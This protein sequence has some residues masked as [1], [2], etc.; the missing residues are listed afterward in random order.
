MKK[1]VLLVLTM[2][3]ILGCTAQ[4]FAATLT[5]YEEQVSTD[6]YL[7]GA[8][9]MLEKTSDDAAWL[10][11][12]LTRAKNIYHLNAI[13]V[14][15]LEDYDDTYKQLL[16]DQLKALDMKICVRI[17]SYDGSTFAFTKQDA[18]S[19]VSQYKSLIEFTSRPENR[20]TVLYY[21][22]NMPVDDPT[23]QANLGGVNS[24]MSKTNQVSYAEEFVRLMREATAGYG[25]TEAKLYLSVFYGWDCSFDVP[26]YASANPDG[27]FI[28]NYSYPVG[29]TLPGADGDPEEIINAACLKNMME[30]FLAD[31][32]GGA[33]LV[34]ECGFHTLEYNHGQWPGQT[35]GLVLDR[36]T[37]GVAMKATV[38]FY[39]KNYPFVEGILYFGY[40]L[41]KE[42]GTPAAVMDWS[43]RYPVDGETEA[44]NAGYAAEDYASDPEA[45]E[46]AAVLL[47]E[48][49]SLSFSQCVMTQ[50]LVLFYRAENAPSLELRSDGRTK[51]TITLPAA[52]AYRAYGIPLVLAQDSNL[53]IVC[54]GGSIRIDKLLLMDKLEAE[55]GELSG[56]VQI[57]SVPEAS[58]GKAIEN[59]TGEGNAARFTGVRGGET[60]ELTYMAAEKTQLH[61]L[62][63]GQE[64]RVTLEAADEFKTVKLSAQVA[65]DGEIALYAEA[66]TGLRVDCLTLSGTPGTAQAAPTEPKAEMPRTNELSTPVVAGII[67]AA[68][69]AVGRGE[70]R[71]RCQ[72]LLFQDGQRHDR[73][74]ETADG[75]RSL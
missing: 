66:D 5:P 30:C 72:R 39:K 60:L 22:L 73:G 11:T 45:S 57:V 15:G 52:E 31:Y 28:N 17:E 63:D 14:Y 2:T 68:L 24:E 23:V 58:A 26:S 67:A 42:E 25:N 56:N 55:Y 9:F 41:F 54:T 7:C 48:G 43:L 37:K 35:A 32:P 44:E 16:F 51:R 34:V 49:K 40:N 3:M 18:A 33:P 20:E 69:A 29:K 4:T 70:N 38:D 53:E 74:L 50:Q 21:A 10:K 1:L 65:R 6:N 71:L 8:T 75:G 61:L 13:T 27:Y 19:V 46:G 12:E 62:L 59:L 64:Y 36:E 47:T